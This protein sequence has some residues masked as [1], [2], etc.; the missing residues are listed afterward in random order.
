MRIQEAP[1]RVLLFF[2]R[3]GMLKLTFFVLCSVFFGVDLLCSNDFL[4][5]K[6]TKENLGQ[7]SKD[8]LKERMGESV[9]ESI[10][11]LFDVS[12]NIVDIL[13]LEN[14]A[15]NSICDAQEKVIFLQKKLSKIAESLIDNHFVYKKNH[16][17]RVED[18][19]N[20]LRVCLVDCKDMR[21]L[22]KSDK[23][24][25]DKIKQIISVI[26]SLESKFTSDACLRSI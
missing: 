6:N 8:A 9:R 1:F 10:N 13:R 11:I 12:R 24:P 18:S 25:L 17:K 20:L 7:L 15:V 4:L 19:L 22:L 26:N 21:T 23:S 2:E 14:V 3:V 16:K 5:K